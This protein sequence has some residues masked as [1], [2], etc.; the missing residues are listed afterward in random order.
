MSG[1]ILVLVSAFVALTLARVPIGLA[2]I[3]GGLAYLFHKGVDPGLAAE[4]ILNAMLQS[5]VLLAIPMFLL[6]ANFVS[7]GSVA[8]RMMDVA[9]LLVGRVRG[10]LGYVNVIVN[11]VFASMS[12]SAVADAAGPGAV[13]VR[14]MRRAGYPAGFSAA[15]TAAGATL[16]PIIPPSI[17]M[18]LYAIIANVSVGALFVGGIIPGVLIALALM[19]GVA[20]QARRLKLP[21]GTTNFSQIKTIIVRGLLPLGLPVV[22][23]GGIR[24]GAFTPTEGAAVAALYALFLVA[25]IYREMN[26]TAIYATLRASLIQSAGVMIIVMGA[27]LV[28]YAVAAEQLPNQVALWF[29]EQDFGASQFL[30]AVMVLFLILGCF[31]DTTIMLLVLVPVLLPTARLLGV[32]LV[33]FGLVVTLN[34]M[35]GMMT[36]PYGILLFVVSGVTGIP[37]R[38]IIRE[39]W[40]FCGILI[41]CL[42]LLAAVPEI[43]LY[44]PRAMG[45]LG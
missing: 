6:C 32:D 22:I 26:S 7:A 5:D 29:T 43:T 9:Q 19:A 8:P 41:G 44:L 13:L 4:Q 20:F 45:L 14:M 42:I 11:I 33:H 36:P 25:V 40:F 31:I 39:S 30:A 3:A 24:I 16:A 2:M 27:F 17:P 35:I 15:L 23:L 18:I 10:G 1:S 12:G 28:N 37:L 21:S 38:E 34:M